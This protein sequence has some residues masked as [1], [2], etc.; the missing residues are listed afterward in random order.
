MCRGQG[1]EA[2]ARTFKHISS[3]VGAFEAE[4]VRKRKLM[5]Q[6]TFRHVAVTVTARRCLWLPVAMHLVCCALQVGVE[7]LL[8]DINDPS[9][10]S[11]ANQVKFKMTALGELKTKL[12]DLQGYLT[13]VLDGKMP[14]N[15]KV[16][17]RVCVC[18]CV[19]VGEGEG[20]YGGERGGCENERA[21]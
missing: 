4:E 1:G 20:V 8:R 11:L 15:N 6:K 10:S 17:V 5:M 16:R 18:A 3:D 2:N 14:A 21:V 12:Q 9:V 13:N 7:H 19:C